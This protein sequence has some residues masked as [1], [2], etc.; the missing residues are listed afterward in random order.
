[1][2]QSTFNNNGQRPTMKPMVMPPKMPGLSGGMGGGMGGGA[3]A[4]FGRSGG[5][6]DYWNQAGGGGGKKDKN[7]WQGDFSQWQQFRQKDPEGWA[8]HMREHGSPNWDKTGTGLRPKSQTDMLDQRLGQFMEGEIPDEVRQWYQK[9]YGQ[10]QPGMAYKEPDS[11]HIYNEMKRQFPDL[12]LKDFEYDPNKHRPIM[13]SGDWVGIP[14]TGGRPPQSG[15]GEMT[16]VVNQRP[17]RR[18]NQVLYGPT[19]K[20]MQR[21]GAF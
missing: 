13:G 15:S 14:G 20:G 12:E 10:M 18:S 21:P 19:L 7:P 4:M 3:P 5:Y 2:Y 17:P 16:N 8:K 1:M 11:W 9:N 6:Q